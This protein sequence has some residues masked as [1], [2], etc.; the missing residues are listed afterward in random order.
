MPDEKPQQALLFIASFGELIL[1]LVFF[2]PGLA[3]LTQQMPEQHAPGA[4]AAKDAAAD[5][6]AYEASVLI[7]SFGELVLALIFSF[8][9]GLDPLAQ[10]VPEQ[11][12][13]G[14][15]A[16]QDA[17]ADQQA[18]EASVLI[19]TFGELFLVLIF[20][21]LPGLAS[22]AQQVPE[23]HTAHTPAPQQPTP[24]QQAHE[25]PLLVG[26]FFARCFLTLVLLLRLTALAQ[27]VREQQVAQAAPT[28]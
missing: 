13:T 27:Q 2:L 18:H 22:L 4:P 20:S 12:P 14:A 25:A 7:A 19:A 9:P 21:F 28:Q 8:L 17:A 5:Q 15:P 23:Q 10:Q 24:D 26:V 3:P 11:H 6:Q 1:A 16:A